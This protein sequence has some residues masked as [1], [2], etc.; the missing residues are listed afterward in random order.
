MWLRVVIMVAIV[1][2][3]ASRLHSAVLDAFAFE[4][5]HAIQCSLRFALTSHE[6]APTRA[7]V[8]CTCRRQPLLF[9]EIKRGDFA[10]GG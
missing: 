6:L 8:R 5:W 1:V 7:C 4:R 9:V 3:Q 2:I 10:L